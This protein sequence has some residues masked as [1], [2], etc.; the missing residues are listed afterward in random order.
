[1]K[2]TMCE[3]MCAL[4]AYAYEVRDAPVM[5]DAR[6][7]GLAHVIG[8]G[9]TQLPG[10]ADHTGQWVLNMDQEL[11]GSLL[12]YTHSVDMDYDDDLIRENV[13]EALDFYGLEWYCR[14]C[15]GINFNCAPPVLQF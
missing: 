1:M 15:I 6:Y 3:W 2:L 10:F 5:T 4:A 7:D 13:K 11:L 9:S 12:D 8:L 14:G